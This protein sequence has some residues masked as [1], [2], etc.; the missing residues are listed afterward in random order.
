MKTFENITGRRSCLHGNWAKLR[1]SCTHVQGVSARVHWCYEFF[2][3]DN[4]FGTFWFLSF[5]KKNLCNITPF[6]F[7]VYSANFGE[8]SRMLEDVKVCLN[9]YCSL[10]LRLQNF[11]YVL[12]LN[13]WRNLKEKRYGQ[14]F[15]RRLNCMVILERKVFPVTLLFFSITC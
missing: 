15:L 5:V 12:S 2:G 10:C 6:H 8:H 4:I 14:R 3:G 7:E 9:C 11:V 1:R 13:I